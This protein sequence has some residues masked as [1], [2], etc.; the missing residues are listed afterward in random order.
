MKKEFDCV[1]YM[2]EQRNKLS[3]EYLEKPQQFLQK[4]SKSFSD[5]NDKIIAR[6]LSYDCR[7][8]RKRLG[9]CA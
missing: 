2:R 3:K 5:I 4:L 6:P 9:T 1:K 8:S 7:S